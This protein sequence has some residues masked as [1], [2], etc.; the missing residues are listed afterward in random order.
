MPENFKTRTEAY[1]SL[2]KLLSTFTDADAASAE[3]AKSA[4]AA[5][6]QAIVVPGLFNFEDILKLKGT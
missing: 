1:T 2:L 6:V 5:I 3:A 4:S